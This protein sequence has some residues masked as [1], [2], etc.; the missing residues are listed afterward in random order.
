MINDLQSQSQTSTREVSRAVG[1]GYRTVLR[2]K[3]RVSGGQPPLT[4]PGPKKTGPLPLDEVRRE[5]ESLRHGR[6]RSRGLCALQ[7][8]YQSVVSRRSVA[9]M[10]AQE[11]A[12]RN[13]ARR[14]VCKH[15]TWKEP[16]LAW[17]IDATERGKDEQ[18]QRLYVH[19]V[20]D[21]CTRYR[22][23]PLVA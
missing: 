20:Q 10:A 2:W 5:I 18:G 17:A 4:S 3:K 21:L 8:R 7:A 12:R 19:A 11:R 22:F 9:E 23:A 14:Q 16:N 6:R 13:L 1:L 15:V